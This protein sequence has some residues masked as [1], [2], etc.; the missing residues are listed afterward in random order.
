MVSLFKA[1]AAIA[2]L[3][4]G[5]GGGGFGVW[6]ASAAEAAP[7]GSAE[8]SDASVVG[9]GSP[10]RLKVS[11]RY[12]VFFLGNWSCFILTLTITFLTS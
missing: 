6:G 10:R 12:L 4:P 8:E 11:G 5:G 7:L 1:L 2:A 9:N 3:N